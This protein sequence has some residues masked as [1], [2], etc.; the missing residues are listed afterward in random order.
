MLAFVIIGS[1]AIH[2]GVKLPLIGQY[3]TKK[4]SYDAD[5]ALIP[6]NDDEH[7]GTDRDTVV[8][9]STPASGVTAK[10]FAWIDKP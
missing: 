6:P 8:P 10:V 9:E 7:P 2:I 5:G 4:R 3:W 1:L